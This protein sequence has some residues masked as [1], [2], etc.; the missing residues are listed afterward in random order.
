MVA[1][2]Q[3]DPLHLVGDPGGCG[4]PGRR[5]RAAALEDVVGNG[6]VPGGEVGRVDVRR[7]DG[8]A[9]ILGQSGRGRQGGA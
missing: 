7:G 2:R 3:A 8:M 9:G 5:A 6:A 1:G 4:L